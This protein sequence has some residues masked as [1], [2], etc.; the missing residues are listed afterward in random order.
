DPRGEVAHRGGGDVGHQGGDHDE[1]EVDLHAAPSEVGSPHASA[2]TS[3]TIWSAVTPPARTTRSVGPVAST[4]VE[5]SPSGESP[6]SR[7]T[8][9]AAPSCRSASSAVVAGGS[10]VRLAL[11]TASGPVRRRS[12]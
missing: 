10:P 7:Y 5:A 4:M 12:A 11:V 3:A 2:P 9:T 1:D 6:P 8:D